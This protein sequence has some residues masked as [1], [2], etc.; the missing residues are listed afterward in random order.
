MSAVFLL[1]VSW[2][3]G[4]RNKGKEWYP[5]HPAVATL[6]HTF[7]PPTHYQEVDWEICGA[8]CSLSYS[9]RDTLLY[10]YYKFEAVFGCVR[11]HLP[12]ETVWPVAWH[13]ISPRLLIGLGIYCNAIVLDRIGPALTLMM[14]SSLNLH[15][16]CSAEGHT[17]GWACKEVGHFQ[18][19]GCLSYSDTGKTICLWF[20]FLF[21]GKSH[22]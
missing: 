22:D 10:F 19:G 18:V 14:P 12:V 5:T 2:G 20:S 16:Y 7:T 1:E 11:R 8:N 17:W 3:W 21:W 4:K 6:P 9:R 13:H 15:Q